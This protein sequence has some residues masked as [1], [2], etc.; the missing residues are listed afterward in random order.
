VALERE[1][2][3]LRS[4]A[5][6]FLRGRRVLCVGVELLDDR[7]VQRVERSAALGWLQAVGCRSPGR[8][9]R[10]VP[11]QFLLLERRAIAEWR[12]IH[13][14]REHLVGSLYAKPGPW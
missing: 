2:V 8:A 7:R 3:V 4:T 10:R 1:A 11:L 14:G 6:G 13:V 5:S 9:K 12:G